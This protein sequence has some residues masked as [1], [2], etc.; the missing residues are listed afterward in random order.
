M[1]QQ[2][3]VMKQ[4][5]KDKKINVKDIDIDIINDLKEK[6]YIIVKDGYIELN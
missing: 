1:V 3:K 4:L 5:K 6:D 2:A